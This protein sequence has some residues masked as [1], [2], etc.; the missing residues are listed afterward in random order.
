MLFGTTADGSQLRG[1][2]TAGASASFTIA[3]ASPG[4][5]F[6]GVALSP[7]PNW[8]TSMTPSASASASASQ[9]V[10]QSASNSHSAP[11]S[12]PTTASQTRT[13]SRS[14]SPVPA[15]AGAPP[16]SGP[17]P[18]VI[19]AAVIVPLAII[20]G[21]VAY[22]LLRPREFWGFMSWAWD[23]VTGACGGG[24]KSVGYKYP[25]RV[26]GERTALSKAAAYSSIGGKF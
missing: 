4:M 23:K 26:A 5:S 17:D 24:G 18:G 6:F 8:E 12:A 10:S 21:I 2:L 20:G 15:A 16:T 25:S 3:T 9:S 11:A 13:P 1:V 22:A 7:D 14:A 19:A